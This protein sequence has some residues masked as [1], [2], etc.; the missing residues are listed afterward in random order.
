MTLDWNVL[1]FFLF[2]VEILKGVCFFI[3]L[4][5]RVPFF[6]TKN[7]TQICQPLTI[8]FKI[9]WIPPRDLEISQAEIYIKYLDL[10]SFD[11]KVNSKDTTSLSTQA[12]MH[13]FCYVLYEIRRVIKTHSST[14]CSFEI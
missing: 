12:F 9:T 13:R 7:E 11:F 1:V 14:R 3:V 5:F 8:Y 10:Y 4:I 6:K 2:L